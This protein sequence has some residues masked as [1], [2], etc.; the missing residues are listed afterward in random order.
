MVATP[1]TPAVATGRTE[2][3]LLIRCL[4]ARRD[5]QTD[6]RIRKLLREPIDWEYLLR[7]AG[8]HGVLPLVSWRLGSFP[9]LIPEDVLESLRSIVQHNKL[10]NLLLAGELVKLL[11]LFRRH[12]IP[13]V[14]YKGPVLAAS[15][16][17]NLALRKPGDLDLLMRREDVRRARDLLRARGYEPMIRPD[18]SVGQLDGGQEEAFFRFEREYGLTHGETGIDVELQWRIM[19]TQFTF[20]LEVEDLRKRL[21]QVSLGRTEIHTV[22]PEDLLLVLCVHG[23]KHFWERLQWVCD[24]AETLRAYREKMNWDELVG[25]ASSLGCRRMLFLGLFLANDVLEVELPEEIS[26]E[27]ASD[28][29]VEELAGEVYEWLFKEPEDL[30]DL[31]EGSA[32]CP[33]HFRVRERL[34]DRLLYWAR[35]F[36]TPNCSDWLSVT[37][38]VRLLSLY[39]VLRPL[40]LAGKYGKRLS[41]LATK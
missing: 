5:A 38:P 4:R 41:G 11:D 39:Y 16:Y 25:R 13:A 18:L 28:P 29:V 40:R 23:S 21:Q 36:V 14:S 22:S 34:Q 6:A 26:Q 9:E 19:P 7:T 8:E 15:V 12:G 27:V 2:H 37:L 17:R 1:G 3:E 30:R 20:P 24:V 35:T 10:R 32:F 33:F 31:L